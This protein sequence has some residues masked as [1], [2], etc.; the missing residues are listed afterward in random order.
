MVA[1]GGS[2]GGT[3]GNSG[4]LRPASHIAHGDTRGA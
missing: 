1:V 2:L 3:E 4:E